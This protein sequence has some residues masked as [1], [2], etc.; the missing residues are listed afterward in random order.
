MPKQVK[1][2]ST[3]DL[4]QAVDDALPVVLGK[5]GCVQEFGMLDV[6]L[7]LGYTMGVLAAATF[8]LD[9]KL[10]WND[11]YWAQFGLTAVFG[12]VASVYYYRLYF[13]E[14]NT[15]YTGTR[16]G[17]AVLVRGVVPDKYSPVY[18]VTVTVDGKQHTQDVLFT[19]WFTKSGYLHEE[20]VKEWFAEALATA[21][22]A[23]Q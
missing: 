8:L 23:K 13:V 18:S 2:N 9:K 7:A 6:K 1:L 14:D 4:R 10:G 22:R 11:S 16:E 21:A 19:K 17:Q 15:K 20:A 3:G 5:L 12:V